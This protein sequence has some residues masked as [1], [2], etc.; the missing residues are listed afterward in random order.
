MTFDQIIK[1]SKV[2][3]SL[4]RFVHETHALTF[5]FFS[6]LNPQVRPRDHKTPSFP[7]DTF[8]ENPRRTCTASSWTMRLIATVAVS[9]VTC[10]SCAIAEYG[11]FIA[12]TCVVKEIEGGR[13]IL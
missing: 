5:L 10:A 7:I 2:T 6:N 13:Y 12:G 4:C 9:W 1:S 3:S 11:N 8:N